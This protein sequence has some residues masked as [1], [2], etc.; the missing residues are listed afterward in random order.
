MHLF[1]S[2][3]QKHVNLIKE[4]SKERFWKDHLVNLDMFC[5]TRV[6]CLISRLLDY[7]TIHFDYWIMDHLTSQIFTQLFFMDYC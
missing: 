3:L 4:S 1:L 7:L 5:I 2:L 6:V